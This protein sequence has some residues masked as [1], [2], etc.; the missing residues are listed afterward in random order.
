MSQHF[1]FVKKGKIRDFD[2]IYEGMVPDVISSASDLKDML[3][4]EFHITN[5]TVFENRKLVGKSSVQRVEVT[6]DATVGKDA[7]MITVNGIDQAA[8]NS[9]ASQLDLNELE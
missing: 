8:A 4:K 6:I 1:I 5:W 3:G 2:D 9:L 7:R